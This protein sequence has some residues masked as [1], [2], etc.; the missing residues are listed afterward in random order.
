MMDNRKLSEEIPMTEKSRLD[1]FY[2]VLRLTADKGYVF[3]C[4]IAHDFSRW[5]ERIVKNYAIP[6]EYMYHADK[7][8]Q[9][10]IHSD[11]LKAYR[12]SVDSVLCGTTDMIQ[13]LTYRARRADGTYA[14]L[15]TR[16]F[17]LSD[18]EGN[19]DYFGGIIVPM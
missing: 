2:N 16:G 1:A 11:D 7:F 14:L 9:E 3:L 8:W 13:P 19:A 10:K 17:I 4:D 5:D 15:T 18:D 12:N 6:S